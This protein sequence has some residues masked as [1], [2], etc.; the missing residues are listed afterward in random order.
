MSTLITIDLDAIEANYRYCM[1]W[2]RPAS[3]A[4]VVKADAY[5]LGMRKVAP[6]L[7]R[8]GCRQ[9]FTATHREGANL[10]GVLADAEIYVFESVTQR[11]LPVFLEHGLVPV[12]I[13]P[14]HAVL[15]AEQARA[16]GQPLPAILHVDTGMTRLGFDETGLRELRKSG[17]ALDWLELRYVMTHF[18]CADEPA[19]SKTHEQLERFRQLR[20]FLPEAPTSI[21]NSAGSLMGSGF[22]GDMAR[23]GI[24]LFGGNPY[25]D[26]DVPLS[27]VLR[28]QS[29]ILQ[30]SEIDA[31]QTV[32]Y[33]ATFTAG[34]R[35]SIATVGIGYADGYP[36]SL[37]NRGI[38]S[39]EGRR[40]P[41]VGRVSMDM[42]ALDVTDLPG[43]LRQPGQMVDL[44][45]PEVSLEEVAGLAGTINYELLT[46]LS[47]R[48]RRRYIGGA[49][50]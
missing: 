45:G 9:F 28:V 26:R 37:G 27:P 17:D 29:R 44:I 19:S 22:S 18:A 24:A 32:G 40:V 42:I 7:R 34:G 3:V 1:E 25:R 11:S 49:G 13:T 21:G 47:Q 36:W 50:H 20:R 14:T 33:G 30:V 46:R 35:R 31:G 10:R 41:V 39:V 6:A 43:E 23:L 2:L 8:A 5:G 38:A 15:W 12:L 48:A 16:L 4:A